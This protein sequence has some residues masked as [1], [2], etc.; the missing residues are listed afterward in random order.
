MKNLTK[1]PENF[2]DHCIKEC[3]YIKFN[4]Q[5]VKVE[6]FADIPDKKTRYFAYLKNVNPFG[7]RRCFGSK[8][9]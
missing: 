3:D 7:A 9:R 8:V 6:K 1:F 4:K 2:C 5:I